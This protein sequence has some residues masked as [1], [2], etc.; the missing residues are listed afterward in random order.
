MQRTMREIAVP[1]QDGVVKQ[2]L[3]E[4][5]EPIIL[6]GEGKPERRER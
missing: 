5:G 3:I 2:R 1:T 4:L 6:F